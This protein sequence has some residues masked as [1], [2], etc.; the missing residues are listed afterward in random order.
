M[1]RKVLAGLFVLFS[2]QQV[3][4]QKWEVGGGIGTGHYLGDIGRNINFLFTRPGGQLFLRYNINGNFVFRV[5]AGYF[6]IYATDKVGGDPYQAVRGA[7]F[8]KNLIEGAAMFEFNFFSYRNP[9]RPMPFSPYLFGG[10]A[11]FRMPGAVPKIGGG[12]AGSYQPC[13][14]FGLGIKVPMGR[15]WNFGTEFGA[16]KTFTDY[17]DN[18][19][20]EYGNPGFQRAVPDT[21]DWYHHLS[22]TLSYTFTEVDCK[23]PFIY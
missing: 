6:M 13:I 9:K 1:L 8:A 17:L 21:K 23:V 5:N 16:R 4:A 19:G 18:L 2:F 15:H 22:L 20:D 14:P 3:N 7:T 12:V 10:F 11:M